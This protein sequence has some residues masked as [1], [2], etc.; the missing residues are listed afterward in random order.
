MKTR[1]SSRSALLLTGA[2]AVALLGTIAVSTLPAAAQMRAQDQIYGSQMMTEQERN[3][4][5]QRMQSAQTAAERDRIRNENHARMQA[6]AKERGV[7]LP[8]Q[9]PGQ[10]MGQG[11]GPGQ[12]MGGGMGSGGGMGPGGGGRR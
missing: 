6:R 2:A 3:E 1:L 10:G 7:T 8:D 5:R 4:Y 9:P 12:G 11:L